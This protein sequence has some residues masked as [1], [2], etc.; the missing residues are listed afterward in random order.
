MSALGAGRYGE[1]VEVDLDL[2]ADEAEHVKILNSPHVGSFL[3]TTE[4]LV[5]LAS[6]VVPEW[7]RYDADAALGDQS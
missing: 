2:I 1:S 6:G 7:L 5:S 3:M 4:D